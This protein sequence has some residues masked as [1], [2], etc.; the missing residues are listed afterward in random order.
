[1]HKILSRWLF[2]LTFVVLLNVSCSS[3]KN[4]KYFGDLSDTAKITKIVN[5]LYQEPKI[6]I[7]DILYISI[8]TLD[9][10]SSAAINEAN[11][12]VAGGV[13]SSFQS[14]N[15]LSGNT[16]N[17]YGYL[18]DK[19]GNV[20]IPVLGQVSLVGLTTTEAREKV[21]QQ[22]VLFYKS[23]SVVLRFANFKITV[24]GEVQRP[25]SYVM[26]N[27]K[28]TLLDAIGYAGDLTI[29]GKRNNV[30]L[31]RRA[32][33]GSVN[34]IRFDLNNSEVFR[35]PYFYLQQNDEI[36]VEPL[37]AKVAS[38]DASQTRNIS[39]FTAVLSLV[40]ILVTRIN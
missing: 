10:A 31:I 5:G 30:L 1:M 36:Y 23:P 27:E 32:S 12:Q 14:A 9:R 20:H 7:D 13:S 34:A 21:E 25:G 16:A 17:S 37:K 2:F 26:P 39:I 28:V 3:I 29:Y 4:Y 22:A 18:V 35:S 11:G 15:I 6:Q 40:I 38:S 8:Q 33:D 19:K 24:L